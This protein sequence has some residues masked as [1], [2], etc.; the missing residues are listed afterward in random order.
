MFTF[1]VLL[2]MVFWAQQLRCT[3]R[4]QHP[5]LISGVPRHVRRGPRPRTTSHADLDVIRQQKL[6]SQS[7]SRNLH[8]FRS[9][10][11][12]YWLTPNRDA[13]EASLLILPEKGGWC[14]RLFVHHCDLQSKNPLPRN[15]KQNVG[16]PLQTART[17][18]SEA[19]ETCHHWGLNMEIHEGSHRKENVR[20]QLISNVALSPNDKT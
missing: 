1:F 3:I 12:V 15:V 9:A 19:R 20:T 8:N 10:P 17:S 7:G 6:L 13:K 11:K 14:P 4:L 5:P 16:L 2:Q 18:N